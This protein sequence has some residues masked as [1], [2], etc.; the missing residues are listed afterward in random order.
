MPAGP[1]A[2]QNLTLDTVAAPT[3]IS[4]FSLVQVFSGDTFINDGATFL[5]VKVGATAT[6]VTVAKGPA[7]S[8]IPLGLGPIPITDYVTA[9][10]TIN[11]E[12]L[13]G[14]FAPARFNTASGTVVVNYSSTT[15]V[16]AGAVKLVPI[17]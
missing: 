14:P 8:A 10:L 17:A 7:S 5:W 6:V 11:R 13:L 1:Y 9:S 12:Y 4:D 15:A 2:V 3:P 16:F